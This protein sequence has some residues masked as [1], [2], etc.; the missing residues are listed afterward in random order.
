[1]VLAVWIL[2]IADDLTGALEAGALF[3][4]RGLASRVSTATAMAGAPDVPVLVIDT[5]TR[6]LPP[7]RARAIV[8]AAVVAARVYS[9]W[10]V[11]KKTDST[12]RG[13]IGTE[14]RALLDVFPER[15]LVYVPA[16]PAMGRTV[17]EG[18]LYVGGVPLHVTVFANDPLNTVRDNSIRAHISDVPAVICDGES[19]ADIAAAA[20][21]IAAN[22]VPPIAAGPAALAGALAECIPLPRGPVRPFPRLS[23]CLVVNGSLH[24]ASLAQLVYARAHGCLY[25]DWRLFDEDPGGTGMDRALSNGVRVAQFLKRSPVEALIVFGGDTVFGI[26][27]ALGGAPFHPYGEIVPGVALSRC[28]ERFWI[29]KAGGF[30]EPDILCKIRRLL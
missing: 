12:L 19:D 3:A 9:P 13:S 14:F 17:R 8:R 18:R 30:G 22:D 23:R 4:A 10:L 27:R 15:P 11:Y 5:E 7:D 6:H 21:S 26:H 16:Y 29:T 28:E 1:M 25:G 24:P 20:Q 2:A